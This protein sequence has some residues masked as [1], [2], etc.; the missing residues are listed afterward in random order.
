M[1][2]TFTLLLLTLTLTT[3]GQ[4]LKVFLKDGTSDA[5]QVAALDSI[6]FGENAPIANG[7]AYVVLGLSSRLMWATCNVGAQR[8]SD[9]GDYTAELDSKD[10]EIWG[11]GWHLPEKVNAE[12]L[13]S[14][15]QWTWTE[16]DGVRGYRV[17]GPNGAS[18][19]LPAA[20]TRSSDGTPAGALTNSFGAYWTRGFLYSNKDERYIDPYTLSFSESN[21]G[22]VRMPNTQLRFTTRLVIDNPQ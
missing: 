22:V 19:F 7:H 11:G 12:E 16:L 8:P 3:Y 6:S 17:T 10:R 18:I 9:F 5:F 4:G 2:R 13:V 15:C 21:R 20:G 14:S 1:R